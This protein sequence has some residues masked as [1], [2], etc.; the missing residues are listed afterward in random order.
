MMRLTTRLAWFLIVAASLVAPRAA[1]AQLNADASSVWVT[2]GIGV[3]GGFSTG[4]AAWIGLGNLV[5]GY[6]RSD[7]EPI[8]WDPYERHVKAALI[9]F[10]FNYGPKRSAA[11]TAGVARSY[12]YNDGGPETDCFIFCSNIAV[13][14]ADRSAPAINIEFNR[15]LWRITGLS[16]SLLAVGGSARHVAFSTNLRLGASSSVATR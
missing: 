16:M 1:F 5:V 4:S 13:P 7:V 6:A 8:L 14:V 11:F 10:R 9:G 3:G 15:D 12:G 2:T